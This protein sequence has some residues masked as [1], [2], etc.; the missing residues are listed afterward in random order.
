MISYSKTR[1]TSSHP[2]WTR[3]PSRKEGFPQVGK[4]VRHSSCSHVRSLTKPPRYSSITCM[5]RTLVRLLQYQR[6]ASAWRG[7]L[8]EGMS[9]SVKKKDSKVKSWIQADDLCSTWYSF[10]S[11]HLCS[12]FSLE[13]SLSIFCVLALLRDLSAHV[14]PACECVCVCLCIRVYVCV[15]AHLYVCQF[16]KQFSFYPKKFCEWLLSCRT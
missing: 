12:A 11:L 2:G 15:C 5:Q 16:S 7:F 3:Q 6:L 1:Y 10:S 4:R 14:L 8:R 9:E 13:I